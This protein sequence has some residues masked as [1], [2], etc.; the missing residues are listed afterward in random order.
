MKKI[1]L[2]TFLGIIIIVSGCNKKI[3]T[4][5]Q[6]NEPKSTNKEVGEKSNLEINCEAPKNEA[7]KSFCMRLKAADSGNVELCDSIDNPSEKLFC[8]KE[9]AVKK[10]DIELCKTLNND[11]YSV[12]DEC[13]KDVAIKTNNPELCKLIED[14]GGGFYQQN[15][16]FTIAVQR[17]DKNICQFAGNP[18]QC[19]IKYA[20][21]FSDLNICN[22]VKDKTGCIASITCRNITNKADCVADSRCKWWDDMMSCY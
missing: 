12:K 20:I 5:N 11:S 3:S 1:T 7:E 17:K 16:A 9:V 22:T 4:T 14:V 2:F 8:I 19:L 6:L 18:E 21:Q 13:I 10:L 15:C